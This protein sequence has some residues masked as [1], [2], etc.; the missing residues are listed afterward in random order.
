MGAGFGTGPGAGFG[1][2]IDSVGA[3]GTG[4][5]TAHAESRRHN[6]QGLARIHITGEDEPGKIRVRL[7]ISMDTRGLGWLLL[8]AGIALGLFVFIVWW[9]MKK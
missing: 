9:T 3:G 5:R 6:S 7:S 2:G 1:I 4:G 8:E